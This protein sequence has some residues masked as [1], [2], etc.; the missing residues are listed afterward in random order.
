MEITE[1]IAG[2]SGIV[3]RAPGSDAER[4]AARWLQERIRAGGRAAELDVHWVRPSW[5]LVHAGHAALAVVATVLAVRFPLAGLGILGAVLAGIL[6]EGAGRPSPLRRLTPER[7]TQC[8]VSP[9]RGATDGDRVRLVLTAHYDTG[10]TGLIYRDGVRRLVAAAQTPSRGALPGP[11]AWMAAGVALLAALAA[12]RAGGTTGMWLGAVALV[13]ALALTVTAALLLDVGLSGPGPGASDDASGVAVALALTGALEAAP[14]RRLDVELVL[15]GAG[16]GPG[17]GFARYVRARRR[18]WDAERVVVLHVAACGAGAPRWWTSDG[19]LLP[20]GLHRQLGA[21]AAR[22]AREETHLRARPLRGRGVTGALVARRAGWPAIAIG[23]R[24]PDGRPPRSH[25][26]GDTPEQID[27]AAVCATFELGLA[28]VDALDR[29]LAE[30]RARS[31]ATPA[32]TL[33]VA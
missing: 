8:V 2:L 13:P 30:Q 31:P 17:L 27:P 11:L 3:A 18:E 23:A 24:A 32:G 14:P 19:P 21:L 6:L 4:R 7:A 10:R 22:V 12:L 28:L 26:P 1:T 20:V 33:R 5:A 15:A 16:E 9:P 29:E 25:Q